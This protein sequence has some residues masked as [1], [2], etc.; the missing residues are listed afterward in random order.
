MGISELKRVKGAINHISDVFCKIIRQETEDAMS[1]ILKNEFKLTK[2]LKQMHI[3]PGKI[4]I[5]HLVCFSCQFVFV[6]L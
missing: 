4:Y 3:D 1:K 2:I 5:Y 6:L